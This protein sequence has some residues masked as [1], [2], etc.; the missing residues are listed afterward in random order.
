MNAVNRHVRRTNWAAIVAL[1]I[2]VMNLFPFAAF[3]HAESLAP[4][5]V[6]PGAV[7]PGE[8]GPGNISPNDI[9]PGSF[10]WEIGEISP[11]EI[12]PG[13]LDTGN[14]RPGNVQPGNVTPGNVNPGAFQPGSV[15]PGDTQPGNVNPGDTRP[16]SLTPGNTQPGSVTPGS[17]SGKGDSKAY[18]YVNWSIN[19][20]FGGSL[21]MAADLAEGNVDPA[22]FANMRSLFL[23]ELGVKAID[24]HLKDTSFDWVSGLPVDGFDAASAW[25][26]FKFIKDTASGLQ[27]T[28]LV[29]GLNVAT[30]GISL[31][32]DSIDTFTNF[33]DAFDSSNSQD[34]RIDYAIDGTGS[35]GSTLM[36]AGVIAAMIP[37]GQTVAVV[38]VSV[39]GVLWVGSKLAKWGRK[40]FKLFA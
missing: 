8:I 24:I 17:F 13:S 21:G 7:Q 15:N 6:R 25:M 14:T 31:V 30:A 19:S 35:F 9:Q 38:L 26:N 16:G 2:L 34:E 11:G 5:D 40:L 27:V 3:V 1:F 18:D 10:Q 20:V 28:G 12:Q 4:G 36:D 29:K 37:G 32:F 23:V 39:G 33:Q 22:T